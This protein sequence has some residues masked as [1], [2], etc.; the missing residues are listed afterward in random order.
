MILGVIFAILIALGVGAFALLHY[1]KPYGIDVAAPFKSDMTVPYDH[2]YLSSQQEST[3]QNIGID[4]A[5]LP[6]SVTPKQADCAIG[7]VGKKRAA[8][9]MAGAT[10][11]LTEI[12]ATK[13]C[14]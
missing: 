6:T 2:P 5:T 8:E 1:F 13:K 10:P 9:I 7:A 4:P 11:T 12:I 3:L 14:L